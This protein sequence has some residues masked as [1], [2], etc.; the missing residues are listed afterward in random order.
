MH[1]GQ[2]TIIHPLHIDAN[3]NKGNFLYIKLLI[4]FTF[5]RFCHNFILSQIYYNNGFQS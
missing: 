5:A 4:A 1:A 3:H 2:I